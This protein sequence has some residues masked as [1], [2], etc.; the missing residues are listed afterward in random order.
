MPVVPNRLG[1]ALVALLLACDLPAAEQRKFQS[2]PPARPLPVASR[3]PL[4]AGSALYVSPTGDDGN[5][6]SSAKPWRTLAQAITKLTS[7]DTLYLR[8]GVYHEH[9]AAKLAGTA[10]KP[11]TIRG[12]PGELAILD[13]GMPEFLTASASA[14]EPC[15]NGVAGEYWSTKTYPGLAP[16]TGELRVT[17][18]GNFADSL[19]PLHGYWNRG[20]LQSDNPYF[21]LNDSEAES[22]KVG[23]AKHVYCGPGVWYDAETG[24]IHCRLAHTKLPGLGDDNYRGETDPRKT[25]LVLAPWASGSVLTL[26]GSQYVRLQDLVLRGA[27]QPTLNL[28]G[29]LNLELDGLTIYGGQAPIRAA[30]VHGLR[31]RHTACRG[32]AAPWTFRGSLKYRSIES[33]LFTTS[34]WEVSGDDGR[35]FEIAYCEFTDSVDGVF[36]GN[37]DTVVF[38]HNLLENV[39]DDG[40]FVT[41]ATSYDGETPGGGHL[42][43]QNRFARCLSTFAF[44]VGH[45]RQKIIADAERGKW[46]TK[47]LGRGL[48][49]TRNVFDFR[50]PVPYYWPTGPDAPQEVGSPGR[51]AGDHG[52]PGWEPMFIAH[53]TLLT[54]DPPRYEYGT[55]GFSRAAGNG[56]RRRIFNNI[57][58]QMRGL[59]GQWLPDGKSDYAADGNLLWSVSEGAA[60][61][62]LP[63][64]RYPREQTPPPEAWTKHD[65][66]ADPRFALFQADWRQPVDLSLATGSP[67]IDQGVELPAGD[68]AFDP[69]GEHDAGAPD[70]GA[71]PAGVAPWRIGC[72]GRMDVCGTPV[73]AEAPLEEVLWHLP[74]TIPAAGPKFPGKPIALVTGYPAFEAP[75]VAYALRK[76]GAQVVEHEKAWLS[77][78]EFDQYAA[79]VV[80]GSFARAGLATT[81]FADDE[82]PLVR[83]YLE[84]GGVLWL[85]RERHDLFNSDAG[86]KL[87]LEWCG[88]RLLASNAAPALL[89]PA[90][91]W[92][93]HLAAQEAELP[94]LAKG[95]FMSL[96]KGEIVAGDKSGKCLLGQIAVGKGRIIYC[97]WSIAA[98]LPSGRIPPTVADE[99]SFDA[100]MRII[101]NIVL[102]LGQ[103]R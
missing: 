75:L 44:G 58:S 47:Q 11:I 88:A 63:K 41:A 4:A 51:F 56:S 38:H 36:I 10:E 96:P 98:A 49:I 97:G 62:A 101:S 82:L 30:G 13:G 14:W 34:G 100:Q 87:L 48:T 39:S 86:R 12:Y 57:V 65:Q 18:L 99:R 1:Y 28:S 37:I 81:K 8:G 85:F 64:P 71:I 32:L 74:L 89:K 80:D 26:T 77:P 103:P 79:V 31:M 66:F 21:N 2:H 24:R 16:S 95:G 42:I 40:L 29:G 54:G 61:P 9:V 6:G 52:S 3:R 50:R 46:G 55:D 5:D 53:N 91:P 84:E 72:G 20:D 27:R 19:T 22:T 69:L 43:F 102:D 92:V 68:K 25:P 90:H 67:A 73:A 83:R 17:L 70:V 78:R 59:P 45:A 33:R 94:W 35:N 60:T 15:P 93:A 76:A 23:V 7:G